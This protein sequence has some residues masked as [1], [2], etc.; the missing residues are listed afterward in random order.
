[1]IAFIKGTVA[2]IGKEQVILDNQGI[3]YGIYVPQTVLEQIPQNGEEVKLYTYMHVREDA[4]QLFGFL[5]QEDKEIFKLLLGV[6]GIG[7]KGALGILS[8]ISPDDLRF[9]VLAGDAKAISKAPGIGSKTAQKVI[10][11]LKDKLKIEDAWDLAAQS[12]SA[13]PAVTTAV[14]QDAIEALTALGYGTTQA[15]KAVSMVEITETMQVEDVL[16]QA[17]RNISKV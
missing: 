2:G 14:K 16:K 4:M 15:A 5:R 7:P 3:G 1:M 17:L 6:S 8:T 11:E 10:I 9:A 13:A 12:A